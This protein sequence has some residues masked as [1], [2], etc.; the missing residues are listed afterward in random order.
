MKAP[1]CDDRIGNTQWSA[2]ERWDAQIA[3]AAYRFAVVASDAVCRIVQFH[4]LSCRREPIFRT[5]RA[6]RRRV[7]RARSETLLALTRLLHA[8]AFVHTARFTRHASLT[9]IIGGS[10]LQVVLPVVTLSGRSS[11]AIGVTHGQKARHFLAAEVGRNHRGIGALMDAV[12]A[13]TICHMQRFVGA[14]QRLRRVHAG[15]GE[16][17]RFRSNE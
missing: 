9:A 15:L 14:L 4:R 7:W 11:S 10:R 8:I 5:N 13:V 6:C 2:R 1:G 3:E 12:A 16:D 17:A